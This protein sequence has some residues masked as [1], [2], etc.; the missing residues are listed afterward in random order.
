MYKHKKSFTAL[1]H[2][3]TYHIQSVMRQKDIR[4]RHNNIPL[5]IRLSTRI[6][7]WPTSAQI[8]RITLVHQLY[9][10]LREGYW[11]SGF[12]LLSIPLVSTRLTSTLS[13]SPSKMKKI[14]N[15]MSRISF[16]PKKLEFPAGWSRIPTKTSPDCV[17]GIDSR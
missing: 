14:F 13:L 8:S 5:S 4:R 10:L 17:V 1:Q 6:T 11:C 15:K 2:A 7:S 16:L 12:V 3:R 9:P